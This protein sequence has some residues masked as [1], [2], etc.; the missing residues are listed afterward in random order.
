MAQTKKDPVLDAILKQYEDNSSPQSTSSKTYDLKNY[1]S[2]YLKEGVKTGSKRIRILPAADGG[3]PFKEMFV[4][5]RQVNGKWK[6]FTCLKNNFGK[7]CPFCE[8]RTELLNSGK[9]AEKELAKKFG[10]RKMYVL[11]VVDRD[12]EEDGVKF[13][14]FNHD[15]TSQGIMD[16]IISIIRAK[17]NISD[18]QTGRDLIF[19][20]GRDHKGNCV[21]TGVVDCDPS[22]AMEDTET[23]KSLIN[24]E[25][26]WEDLYSVKSYEYLEIVVLGG[27]PA[28]DKANEK[29]VDKATLDNSETSED[30]NEITMGD[31]DDEPTTTKEPETVTTAKKQTAKE[32]VKQP[33]KEEVSVPEEE[34]EDDLPF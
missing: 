10:S 20:I 23:L 7:P 22:P 3:T 12:H 32:T 33:Q 31:D 29:W 19:D 25:R 5:S 26:K 11:R 6:K 27:E 8:A 17:G 1:F 9:E 28:W 24:D 30:E 13:W 14:R 15:Y 2:I 21:V 16:K 18:P 4:H 34:E